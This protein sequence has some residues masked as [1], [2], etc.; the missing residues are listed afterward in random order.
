MMTQ[1]KEDRYGRPITL[2]EL[3]LLEPAPV[4]PAEEIELLKEWGTWPEVDGNNKPR[5]ACSV[6]KGGRFWLEPFKPALWRC[7]DCDNPRRMSGP[8]LMFI[9]KVKRCPS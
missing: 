2:Y 6:C 5:E 4:L 1:P 3:P 7:F 9:G 8:V